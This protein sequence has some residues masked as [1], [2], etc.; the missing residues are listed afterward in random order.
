VPRP[1]RVDGC[2]KPAHS[3]GLCSMHFGRW[4]RNG[5]PLKM[6][7]HAAHAT[8]APSAPPD[9][10]PAQ[11]LREA[12]QRQRKIGNG[13]EWAWP[14]A[15]M[16]AMHVAR[17]ERSSWELVFIETRDE[18]RSAYLKLPTEKPFPLSALAPVLDEC[19]PRPN[20]RRSA[21]TAVTTGARHGGPSQLE[22]Q[23]VRWC[24]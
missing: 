14:T 8:A 12:L 17:G 21:P 20:H 16:P 22:R 18:W 5:S 4:R 9:P 2:E 19:D 15:L 3:R 6:S 24:G 10:A 13:F 7:E 11:V 23:E 1:C